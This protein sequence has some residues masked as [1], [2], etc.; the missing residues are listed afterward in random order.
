M[1]LAVSQHEDATKRDALEAE[2]S[3]ELA[4]QRSHFLEEQCQSLEVQLQ[5][6]L[7]KLTALQEK[8]LTQRPT[9]VEAPTEMTE[10]LQALRLQLREQQLRNE[11]IATSR[12]HFKR[13]VE[14]L[15]G[16][17]MGGS[18]SNAQAPDVFQE[19]AAGPGP[20]FQ[21]PDLATALRQVQEDLAKLADTW[22]ETPKRTSKDG[23]AETPQ[24]TQ[25]CHA[26]RVGNGQAMEAIQDPKRLE[27]HLAWLHDQR[28][29]LL[30][31]GLYGGG[32]PV[33]Q[34]LQMKIA[35]AEAQLKARG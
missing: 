31:S 18:H 22:T 27:Q 28:R 13:K 32:D 24:S 12:D 33:L 6:H 8:H 19:V 20:T 26:S 21:G 9:E 16:R 4:R 23:K 29:E 2:H 34:A 17:L 1:G 30:E 10:E 3:L 25:K 15:C 35:Q 14:E 5:G 11:A 7:T